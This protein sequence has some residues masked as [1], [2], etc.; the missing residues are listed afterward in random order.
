M[1]PPLV[2]DFGYQ[3]IGLASQVVLNGTFIAPPGTD[4]FATKFIPLLSTPAS[5]QA[6]GPH[7]MSILLHAYRKYWLKA[8]ERTSC[9]PSVISFSTLKAGAQNGMIAEFECIMTRI[10]PITGYSSIR[11]KKCIDFMIFK[12]AGL[13]QVTSL[14]KIILFQADCTYAFEFS[15]REMMYNAK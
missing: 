8:R 13:T 10:P 2:S 15:G 9:Y 1:Q 3:G 5:I 14:C 11:W 6:V 7:P 4:K 12:K